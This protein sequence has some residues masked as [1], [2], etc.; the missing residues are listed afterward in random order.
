MATGY[1]LRWQKGRSKVFSIG[2]AKPPESEFFVEIDISE[3][4]FG[5]SIL[6]V[7]YS[8]KNTETGEI[9]TSTVLDTSNSTN[10]ATIIKPWIQAGLSVAKY[11]VIMKVTSN[12][13]PASVET[14][15][16]IFETDDNLPKIGPL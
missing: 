6:R 1:K 15:Y 3:W 11:C 9:V 12:G 10:T 13:T 14:W 5:E 7:V 4:L 16:L 2:D 8:A